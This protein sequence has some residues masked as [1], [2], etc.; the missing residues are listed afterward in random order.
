[1]DYGGE[2]HGHIFITLHSIGA[3]FVVGS[4][5]ALASLG[6][7]EMRAT[8]QGSRFIALNCILHFFILLCAV[9]FVLDF[10]YKGFYQR[11]ALTGVLYVFIKWLKIIV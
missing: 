5:W 1:M 2:L 6:L 7:M 10:P 8:M 4:L 3:G 9:T 11:P